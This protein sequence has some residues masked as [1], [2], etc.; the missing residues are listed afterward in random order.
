MI[1]CAGYGNLGCNGG[2]ICSL[3]S[4]LVDYDV[5][6]TGES[7]YPTTGQSDVCQLEKFVIIEFINDESSFI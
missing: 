7:A 4:W 1:D 3:L 5:S 2:D 6:I